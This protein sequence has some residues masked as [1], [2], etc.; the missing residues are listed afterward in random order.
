MGRGRR[1]VESDAGL[2]WVSEGREGREDEYE[3]GVEGW[4]G[5]GVSSWRTKPYHRRWNQAKDDVHEGGERKGNR[6]RSVSGHRLE[7]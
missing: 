5:A 1:E 2:E 6:L 4:V 3:E 7:R